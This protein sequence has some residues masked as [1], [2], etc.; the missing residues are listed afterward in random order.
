VRSLKED[1]FGIGRNLASKGPE[2]RFGRVRIID[3]LGCILMKE[4]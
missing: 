2:Q 1:F 4:G 3:Q